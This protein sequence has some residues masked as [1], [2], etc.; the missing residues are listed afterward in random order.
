MITVIGLGVEKGD[1]TK[2]GEQAILRAASAGEKI[3]VRT[4]KTK[5]YQTVLELGVA[6]TCLD[7]IY[8]RSRNFATLAKNLAKAVAEGGENAVYLVDGAATEDNSVKALVKRTRG[9]LEIIDGVSRVTSLVRAA[10]FAGCSYTAVSAYE[11]VEKAQSGELSLPLI[12]YDLDD[13]SLAS[14]VKLLLGDLFGEEMNA[15]YIRAGK[16]EKISLFELDRKKGYDYSSAVAIEAVGLLEKQRFTIEDLES[17]TAVLGI[18]YRRT[19]VSKCRRW[20]RRTSWW[21]QSTARTTRK[22]WRKRGIFCYKRCSTPC[23]KRKRARSI[24]PTS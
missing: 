3:F 22:F 6:H 21:T 20:R 5:S 15:K 10:G 14:D 1:L 18:G 2:R 9:K 12:V 19:T 13:R 4:A 7:E 23:S 8:E 11:L 17:L 24:S 16:A